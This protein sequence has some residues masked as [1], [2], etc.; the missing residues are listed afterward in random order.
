MKNLCLFF[1]ICSF[2]RCQA[3]ITEELLTN[4]EKIEYARNNPQL[5]NSKCSPCKGGKCEAI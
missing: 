1:L 3:V 5:V 2:V 4:Q